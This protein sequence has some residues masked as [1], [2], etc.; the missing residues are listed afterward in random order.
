MAESLT[1]V[2]FFDFLVIYALLG[3]VGF[4]PP[5]CHVLFYG[6]GFKPRSLV[7]C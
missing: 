2:Q 3:W 5:C 6:Y 4:L 7:C 1:A